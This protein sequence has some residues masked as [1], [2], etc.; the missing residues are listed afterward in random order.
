VGRSKKNL[1]LAWEGKQVWGLLSG[2]RN[3]GAQ[4]HP[5]AS[6]KSLLNWQKRKGKKKKSIF[7]SEPNGIRSL[8][9]RKAERV[10]SMGSLEE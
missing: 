4:I 10:D 3:G 8:V 9:E 6:K 5:G 1:L 2:R 7:H